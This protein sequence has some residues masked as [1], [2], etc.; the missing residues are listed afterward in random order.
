MTS[1]H[2]FR[3]LS[4]YTRSGYGLSS[5]AEIPGLRRQRA[6]AHPVAGV[7]LGLY[8][9][10]TGSGQAKE[11]IRHIQSERILSVPACLCARARVRSV[12]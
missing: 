4:V 7:R 8:I 11:P 1:L 12:P 2:S 9:E 3:T 10:S 6:R 5:E